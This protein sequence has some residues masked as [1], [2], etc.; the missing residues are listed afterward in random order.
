MFKTS[1]S[2]AQKI[3]NILAI[4]MPAKTVKIFSLSYY[5]HIIIMLFYLY[6]FFKLQLTRFSAWLSKV[7]V[8]KYI[9]SG[10][11]KR[12]F[13]YHGKKHST[14]NWEFESIIKKIIFQAVIKLNSFYF[15]NNYLYLQCIKEMFMCMDKNVDISAKPSYFFLRNLFNN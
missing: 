3:V 8:L 5:Q 4:L 14:K 15:Q 6:I 1:I 2:N 12:M 9:M 13:W 7:L 11:N 10:E